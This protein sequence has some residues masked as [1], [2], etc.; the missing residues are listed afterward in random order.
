MLTRRNGRRST[1]A[2][3]LPTYSHEQQLEDRSIDELRVLLSGT[4][5]VRDQRSRDF[6]VDVTFEVIHENRATNYTTTVQVKARSG[7]VPNTDGSLSL[8]IGSSNTDYLLSAAM[9]LVVLYDADRR[10]FYYARVLDEVIRLEQ[11]GVKF[12][13]QDSVTLRMTT[14]VALHAP[15]SLFAQRRRPDRRA[16]HRRRAAL[17]A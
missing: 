1:V 11:E 16:A 3:A 14:A 17:L 12:R 5:V 9:S 13:A 4:F 2:R 8:P 10:A 15:S 7:L 6:G